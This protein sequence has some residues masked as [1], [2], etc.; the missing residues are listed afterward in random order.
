MVDEAHNNARE[1]RDGGFAFFLSFFDVPSWVEGVPSSGT[2]ARV[3]SSL[4][5]SIAVSWEAHDPSGGGRTNA[6]A[7]TLLGPMIPPGLA[8]RYPA[9]RMTLSPRQLAIISSA[10]RSLPVEK[11]GAYLQRI[12]GLLKQRASSPFR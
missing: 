2:R 4:L 12:E 7:G 8:V 1:E 5:S 9:A 10:A 6:S 11:R 3:G